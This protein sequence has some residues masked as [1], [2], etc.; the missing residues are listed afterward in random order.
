MLGDAALRS[1]MSAAGARYVEANFSWPVL[2]PRYA[3]FLEQA[4]EK[5][6]ATE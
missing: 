6:A 2:V 1:Q 4:A 3:R 5:A